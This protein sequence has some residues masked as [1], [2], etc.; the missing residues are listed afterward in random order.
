MKFHTSGG[1][2]TTSTVVAITSYFASKIAD[3]L[4]RLRR[5]FVDV[6]VQ[7]QKASC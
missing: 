2:P 1:G 5:E 4:C 6:A 3:L 7:R